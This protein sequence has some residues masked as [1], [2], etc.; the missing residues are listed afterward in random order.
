LSDCDRCRDQ[1]TRLPWW[2][3]PAWMIAMMRR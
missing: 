3:L 2:P 1:S